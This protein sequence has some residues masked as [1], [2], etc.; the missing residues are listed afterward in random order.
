MIKLTN[1]KLGGLSR[2]IAGTIR[3]FSGTYSIPVV[4]GIDSR[5]LYIMDEVAWFEAV[6]NELSADPQSA[7]QKLVAFRESDNAM[8]VCVHILGS[9]CSPQVQ[10]Q[11]L[12]ILQH[13]F[14]KLWDHLPQSEK[15]SLK[16]LLWIKLVPENV[17]HYL[18]NKATQA[19]ALL[20]K[21][22][23]CAS[24][25]EAKGA[26]FNTLSAAVQSSNLSRGQAAIVLRA[27]VEEFSGK[28]SAEIGAPIEFHRSSHA[29]FEGSGLDETFQLAIALFSSSMET[30]SSAAGSQE[31]FS[32]ACCSISETSNLLVEVISWD[33][34]G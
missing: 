16:E 20:W 31:L 22:D 34:G 7:S 15:E 10:F 23:W 6:C 11:G 8:N 27:V 32:E 21:R 3:V 14:L 30:F 33:F 26:L 17:P 19:F 4:G 1:F 24:S 12:V 9:N 2:L 29:A 28:S 18:R 25:A 5:D 13:A